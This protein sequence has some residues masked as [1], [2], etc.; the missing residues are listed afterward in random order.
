MGRTRNLTDRDVGI[1]EVLTQEHRDVAALFE[2]IE[3]AVDDDPSVARD[4]FTVLAGNL[5]AHA[6]SEQQVVYPRF[7]RIEELESSMREAIVEHQ[8]VETM[9]AEI[10]AMR[11]DDQEWLARVVVLKELVQHHVQEE[12]G[13]I[14]TTAKE[15]I[16]AAE[17]RR[18]AQSFLA[19]KARRTGEPEVAQARARTQTRKKGLLQRLLG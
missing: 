7:M 16:D 9:I 6:R 3:A 14:F 13:E 10:D 2:Q 17:S 15:H 19:G 18:L 4:L 1:F 8:V 11:P 5:L 12:E